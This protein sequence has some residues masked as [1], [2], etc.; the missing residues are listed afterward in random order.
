MTN[1]LKHYPTTVIRRTLASVSGTR[2]TN[3]FTLF[4]SSHPHHAG[5]R[6][7]IFCNLLFSTLPSSVS[8][9]SP[10]CVLYVT[11]RGCSAPRLPRLPPPP[12]G[13]QMR[14]GK[15]ERRQGTGRAA[16][17]FTFKTGP[18]APSQPFLHLTADSD[19]APDHLKL[20]RS[21][22]GDQRVTSA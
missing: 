12:A 6:G 21:D 11:V 8:L 22:G 16:V 3:C 18:S 2:R 5:S 20:H 1:V 19:T 14:G 4:H 17:S 13:T 7:I 10:R 15:G 9:P